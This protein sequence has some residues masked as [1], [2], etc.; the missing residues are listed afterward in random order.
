MQN[1][2]LP[3]PPTQK[4]PRLHPS[5]PHSPKPHPTC[6]QTRDSPLGLYKKARQGAIKGFTGIDQMYERPSAPDLVV[7]TETCTLEE[8]ALTVVRFLQEKSIIPEGSGQP[9]APVRELFVSPAR[10]GQARAEARALKSLEIGVVDVQ[11]LQVL[12][13]GWAAPLAGFMREDQYLQVC[14][15]ALLLENF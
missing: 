5:P 7:T 13:E 6:I 2:T 4:N 10:L 15:D 9:G 11:W 8:S 1:R 3:Q 12:A 14:D